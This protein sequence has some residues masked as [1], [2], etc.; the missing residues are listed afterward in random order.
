MKPLATQVTS[1]STI[2]AL[3]GPPVGALMI[4][5]YF[6]WPMNQPIGDYLSGGM[7]FL[8]VM[9]VFVGYLVGVVPAALAGAAYAYSIYR[10][11]RTRRLYPLVAI[12]VS[13][14]IGFIATLLPLW[15]YFGMST[16]AA[17]GLLWPGAIGAGTSILCAFALHM[18]GVLP[19]NSFKP[20][21]LRGSA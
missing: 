2:Y 13:G 20:R 6:L 21:P 8:A 12:L 14:S 16:Q 17:A 18:A 10:I 15:I 4:N 5:V 9:S 1:A 3:V 19:N 11:T 7:V